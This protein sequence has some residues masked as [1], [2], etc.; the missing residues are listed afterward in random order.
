MQEGGG[1]KGS[2]KQCNTKAHQK[3]NLN[4]TQDSINAQSLSFVAKNL[5][6][7][8]TRNLTKRKQKPKTAY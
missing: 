6:K 3:N 5:V 4:P 7:K 2:K 8:E 1:K